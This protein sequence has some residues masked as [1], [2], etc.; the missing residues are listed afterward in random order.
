M[1][2]SLRSYLPTALT[3][4]VV[5]AGNHSSRSSSLSPNTPASAYSSWLNAGENT[6]STS[7]D[8]TDAWEQEVHRRQMAERRLQVLSIEYGSLQRERQRDRHI[9]ASRQLLQQGSVSAAD[10]RESWS[11]RGSGKNLGSDPSTPSSLPALAP[12][13]P[14]LVN[15]CQDSSTPQA[16]EVLFRARNDY[17]NQPLQVEAAACTT[18]DSENTPV[19]HHNDDTS[20]KSA[21]GAATAPGAATSSAASNAP[22]SSRLSALKNTCNLLRTRLAL[23]HSSYRIKQDRMNMQAEDASARVQAITSTSQALER[24][25]TAAQVGNKALRAECKRQHV[26]LLAHRKELRVTKKAVSRPLEQRIELLEV[27]LEQAVVERDTFRR[28]LQASYREFTRTDSDVGD[29]EEEEGTTGGGGEGANDAHG[30]VTHGVKLNRIGSARGER[31]V[32][33]LLCGLPL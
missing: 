33:T 13:P 2:D 9:F 27:Q 23:V 1:L 24:Q 29:E 12:D 17:Y 4:S 30:I 8:A 6:P 26:L 11:G 18:S 20:S 7:F 21:A 19:T 3:P 15:L 28:V 10:A 25:L 16:L 32:T 22:S 5:T 14:S 31:Y